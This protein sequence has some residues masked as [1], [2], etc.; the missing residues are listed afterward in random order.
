M[1]FLINYL[2]KQ[3]TKIIHS[4]SM[5]YSLII[6]FMFIL[7]FFLFGLGLIKSDPDLPP[8]N[9]S[10]SFA[11]IIT[12]SP[13]I[14]PTASISPTPD[15]NQSMGMG[16]ACDQEKLL[17]AIKTNAD[18]KAFLSVSGTSIR[19]PVVQAVDNEYYLT[20][21]VEKKASKAGSLFFD[22]RC[23]FDA[24]KGHYIIYGHNMRSGA[25]FGTLKYYKSQ[26]F[27]NNH[28]FIQLSLPGKTLKFEVF[29]AYVTSTHFNF[30]RTYFNG[31]D[32]YLRFIKELQRRSKFK[33]DAVLTAEDVVLTLS[34]CTYEI[35]DG[36][37]V[38]HARLVQ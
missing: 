18:V 19:Y 12:P 37:F 7:T 5:T 36:R 35:T 24:L 11:P 30:I 34:T 38:V 16:Y 17:S 15:A 21:N 13:T 3:Y 9:L 10:T 25:M 2:K 22:Y 6:F 33:T 32:D 4:F 28:R 8:A 20:R 1:K 31:D 29:S 26:S 27:F 14:F 23:A